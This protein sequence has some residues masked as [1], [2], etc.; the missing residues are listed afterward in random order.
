VVVD[1][2]VVGHELIG[3]QPDVASHQSVDDFPHR[4]DHAPE[5]HQTLAE[6]EATALDGLVMRSVIE[7]EV[8]QLFDLVV[9]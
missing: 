6:L 3:D 4:E 5:L 1:V 2:L 8:F 7:Q 9:E